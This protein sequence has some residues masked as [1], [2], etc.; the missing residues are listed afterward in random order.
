MFRWNAR[1]LSALLLA[2]TMALTSCST[3]ATPAA[4]TPAASATAAPEAAAHAKYVFLFIGDGMGVAQRSAAELYLAATAGADARPEETTPGDEHL[5]GPGYG[6]HLRSHQ[7]HPGFGLD[8]HCHRHRHQDGLRRHLHEPRRQRVLPDD[9]R[10]RQGQRWKVGVISTVSLDHAT[11]AVFY[12]HQASRKNMYDISMQLANSDFD[13]FAGGQL[14]KPTN[15]DDPTAPSAID[16]AIAN[17]FTVVTDRA[18][19]EALEPGV[20]RVL[21][22]DG[23]VDD[24]A[25]MYY[26]M[27]RAADD[28]ALEDYV[29]KGIE[30]LDN[31]DG[32]FMMIE[33][34]KIDWACHANDAAASI[35]DTL[36]FDAAIA[37]PSSSTTPIPMRP[38][39]W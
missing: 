39:S 21:A 7:R 29:T 37:R 24:D 20:G 18:A 25:A 19:F 35:H 16:T 23:I 27:D 32:F 8:G 15:A 28:L 10:D 9:L 1:V 33:G 22:M 26:E 11:P 13:Y 4:A 6:H 12:S 14:L 34:G 3:A 5:P 38:S 36:A 17:G 2:A 30:L 31:P